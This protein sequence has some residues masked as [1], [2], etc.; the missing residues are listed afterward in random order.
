V[1]NK[2]R[3]KGNMVVG[4]AIEE[5]LRCCTKYLQ[6]FITTKQKVRDEKENPC[7][8]DEVVERNG[9]P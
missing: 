7:M 3:P 1:K 4:Y 9:H 6:N 5:A 8:V 2:V